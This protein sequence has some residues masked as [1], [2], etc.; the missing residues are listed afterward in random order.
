MIE[1]LEKKLHENPDDAA[2]WLVYADALQE[3]RDPRGE[4]IALG[5]KI[6]AGKHDVAL[7]R[8][9]AE[10]CRAARWPR[11]G[12]WPRMAYR[13]R[14]QQMFDE[15][16]ANKLI[17]VK[18]RTIGPASK[19]DDIAKWKAVAGASWPDGMTAL[20]SELSG[21]DLEYTVEGVES[22]GGGIHIPSLSL[23]DHAALE[24]ELWFD[25]T[26]EESALHHIRPID[27]FVPEAYGVLYL[28]PEKKKPAEVA[29]H[30]CGEE[31]V[32]A[33][34]SYR[35]WLELLFRSRGV[36]Y[37]LQLTLGPQGGKHTWVEDGIAKIAELFPDFDP[38][39]MSPKKKHKEI[40]I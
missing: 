2:T 19:P 1:A 11:G 37:W 26:E 18:E 7:E 29:F 24:D 33:G 39:S 28:R 21:V 10:R 32:E 40:E 27:R 38:K 34:L 16:E 36:R 14:F 17:K 22:V 12:P 5:E 8:R 31:L 3:K 4:A 13:V 23:W 15:L 20:Y 35:E 6:R 25:F 30:Y 9:Y